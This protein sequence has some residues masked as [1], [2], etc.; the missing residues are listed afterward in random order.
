MCLKKVFMLS[1]KAIWIA[2]VYSKI[3]DFSLQLKKICQIILT[4]SEFYGIIIV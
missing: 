4:Y 1:Y 3:E 2:I